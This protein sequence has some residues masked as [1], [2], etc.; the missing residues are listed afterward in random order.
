MARRVSTAIAASGSMAC[1]APRAP[2]SGVRA[3]VVAS[4]ARPASR[5]SASSPSTRSASTAPASTE[6]S[7]S[8]S[9]DEDQAGVRADD[10]IS[11][12]IIVSETI[13][14]SSTTTT[15]WFR[16]L[17]RW[18]RNRVAFRAG[19][20][21]AGAGSAPRG[22]E[23]GPVLG[24]QA[25]RSRRAR[26]PRAAR[27]PCRSGRSARSAAGSAATGRRAGRAVRATVGG[28]SGAGAAGQHGGPAADE[29]D[30]GGGALLVVAGP[31]EDPVSAAQE[32]RCRRPAGRGADRASTS[33]HHLALLRQ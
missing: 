31:A 28:L 12:A 27:R 24:R 33:S 26:P 18:C 8:G 20:P 29:R 1:T 10:S 7:W 2:G 6:M 23:P 15:S 9:P 11:R 22:A 21:A 25:S 3:A 17:P 19:S 5:E 16:R 30:P 32:R 14:D 13:E 4:R